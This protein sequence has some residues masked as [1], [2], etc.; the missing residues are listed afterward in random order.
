[1]P[2]Y[3]WEYSTT[4]NAAPGSAEELRALAYRAGVRMRTVES[5][6]P[7]RYRCPVQR[8]W[9]HGWANIR[10]NYQHGCYRLRIDWFGAKDFVLLDHFGAAELRTAVKQQA[11]ETCYDLRSHERRYA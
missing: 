9:K 5:W 2:S 3:S 6:V 4:Y 8:T 1:M 11:F 10:Y 7:V